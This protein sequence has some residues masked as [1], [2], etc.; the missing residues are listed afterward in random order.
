MSTSKLAFPPDSIPHQTLSRTADEARV[1]VICG[2]PAMGKS[3]FL[4]ELA[5]IARQRGR[6]VHCLQWDI[7]LQSFIRPEII[8]AY[9]DVDGVTHPVV[10]RAAGLWVRSSVLDWVSR[11]PDPRHL[12]II[13]A[14]LVGGR[15]V[16][17]ARVVEDPAET[18]LSSDRARFLVPQPSSEV[19]A[20]IQ[21]ARV[22][23]A[24]RPRHDLDKKNARPSV[25][26]SLWHEILEV[27]KALDVPHDHGNSG[28]L[29]DLYSAVYALLLRHRHVTP[30]P[31][32][33]II[34]GPIT[35]YV[36]QEQTAEIAPTTAEAAQMIAAVEASGIDAAVRSA[37]QW[38]EYSRTY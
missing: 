17:L 34:A 36:Y 11:H 32:S 2:I 28:Y 3:L 5:L 33:Q 19:R 23:T 14:P 9:P 31:V 1:A 12:L 8:A 38:Y 37:Q 26:D 25:V 10:R 15:F 20:A 7:A 30:I 35:P 21:A 27:A 13:E 24:A 22:S 6:I 18:L 16:E 29:S 4:C